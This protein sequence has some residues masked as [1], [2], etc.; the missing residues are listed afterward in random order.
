MMSQ[1]IFVVLMPFLLLFGGSAMAADERMEKFVVLAAYAWIDYDQSC[2]VVTPGGA[3]IEL[4]PLL[5]DYPTRKSMLVFGGVGM[6]LLYL[7]TEILPEPWATIALDSA[8]SSEAWNIEDNTR[9][10]RNQ[11]RGYARRIEGVP[12][13]ITVRF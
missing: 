2:G 1:M 7:A 9:A 5:K 8:I 6:G 4:N 12:I 10:E 3:T 13:I 11:W